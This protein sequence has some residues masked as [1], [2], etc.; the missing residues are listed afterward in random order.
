MYCIF[1]LHSQAELRGLQNKPNNVTASS[2]APRPPHN[3]KS[4]L[5]KPPSETRILTR[6]T[7]FFFRSIFLSCS[8]FII[9][10]FP[11]DFLNYHY[12]SFN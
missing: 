1:S 2:T 12:L 5:Q 10:E 8:R 4:G 3:Q 6:K 9:F 7:D 11:K